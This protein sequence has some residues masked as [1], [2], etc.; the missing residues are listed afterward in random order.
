MGRK[1]RERKWMKARAH[2]AH[3]CEGD[4]EES[5]RKVLGDVLLLTRRDS[6]PS[7]TSLLQLMHWRDKPSPIVRHV[8]L[9]QT[10]LPLC[11]SCRANVCGATKWCCRATFPGATKRVMTCK[12]FSGWLLLKY[13]LKRLK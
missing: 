1:R 7:A 11:L 10:A 4:R 13:L 5:E 2:A 6:R 3:M 8:R 9:D 12:L